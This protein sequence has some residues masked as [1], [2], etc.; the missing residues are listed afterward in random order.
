MDY[1]GL[2]ILTIK[3]WYSLLLIGEA[4]DCLGQ[5]KR[6]TQLNLT[7]VYYQMRIWKDDEWKTAFCTR[8]KYFKYQVI[9]FGL[10]N[11][12]ASFRS[13]INK[14][15]TEKLNIFVLMYL[16]DILIYTK[17]LGRPHVDVK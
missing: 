6:F 2:N 12:S 9:V 8:N 16:N 17:D 11:A 13:Y 5:A 14:I 4:L 7:S 3:N 1:Q 15:F 10:S